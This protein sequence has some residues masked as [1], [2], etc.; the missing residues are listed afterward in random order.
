MTARY[1]KFG[2]IYSRICNEVAYNRIIPEQRPVWLEAYS[3]YPP[4]ENPTFREE[5]FIV[6]DIT[7][8]AKP[9]HATKLVYI[10]DYYRAKF[11]S[12]YGNGGKPYDTLGQDEGSFDDFDYDESDKKI[13]PAN[14]YL[15]D[16]MDHINSMD[17][18]SDTYLKSDDDTVYNEKQPENKNVQ[19]VNNQDYLHPVSRLASKVREL[20]RTFKNEFQY[21]KKNEKFS[22]NDENYKNYIDDLVQMRNILD[23]EDMMKDLVEE[24]APSEDDLAAGWIQRGEVRKINQPEAVGRMF[25]RHHGDE[26]K[27]WPMY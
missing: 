12:K 5:D 9:L 1:W 10:E 3:A 4:F 24:Y 27:D 26:I 22:S 15:D 11:Q 14:A 8:M 13:Q 6:E 21:L 17:L 25:G 23:S 18:N 20:D 19:R 7:F 16:I 2:N